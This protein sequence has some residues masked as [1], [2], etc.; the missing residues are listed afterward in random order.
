MAWEIDVVV[1]GPIQCNCYIL[2][3]SITREAYIIDP[4]AESK[5]IIRHLEKSKFDLKA[6]L[7]THAHLDHVGGIEMLHHAIP[8]PVYYHGGDQPLYSNLSMQAELFGFSLKELQAV[9]PTIGD[10]SLKDQQEFPIASGSIRVIH[11]PGHTP[12]SVCFHATG[13]QQAIFTG[14]TLF[15]GSIGRTDLWGGSFEQIMDSIRNRLMTLD[16]DLPVLPGH[17]AAT[18][19]GEERASNPF[20]QDRY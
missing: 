7:I 1:V 19:I 8:V 4:G 12:G 2:S 10:P 3:D 14:D 20:L 15:E 11:T 17:G 6:A 16:D 5:D 13:G 18:T 9:Q